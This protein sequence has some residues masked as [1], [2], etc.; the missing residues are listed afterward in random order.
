VTTKT[1]ADNS[2]VIH[3]RKRYPADGTMAIVTDIRRENMFCMLTLGNHAIVTADATTTDI[4][5]VENGIRPGKGT[6]AIVAIFATLN[7][8]RIFTRRYHT[9]VT[10]LATPCYGKMIDPENALPGAALV[11]KFT[12]VGSAD[13]LHGSRAGL[14]AATASMTLNASIR[15][16]NKNTLNMTGFA[17]NQGV[18]EIERKRCFIMIETRCFS[19]PTHCEANN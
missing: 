1:A 19:C 7:M 3:P 5:M 10:T 12:I 16:A 9:I 18:R 11:T 14:Y 6:M 15:R 13:M 8:L 17:I 4:R 2:I